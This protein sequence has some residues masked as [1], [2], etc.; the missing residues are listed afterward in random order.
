MINSLFILSTIFFAILL[1]YFIISG[2]PYL[3]F[4]KIFPNYFEKN[5]I[6]TKTIQV[7]DIQR[8]IWYSSQAAMIFAL[9]GFATVKTT[10]KSYTLI[11]DQIYEYPLWWFFLSILIALILH[12]AYFYWTHRIMHHKS[13]YRYFHLV[14]HKSVAPSPWASYSFHFLESFINGLIIPLMVLIL[15]IHPLA[16]MIFTL[17]SFIINVYGHLGYEIMPAHF[18][19]SWM[20][21]VFNSSVHHNLHHSR[22]HGNYGLYL[23]VWDRWMGT[24][25]KDY[26]KEFE[27]IQ[28]Q[29]KNFITNP[30]KENNRE[31]LS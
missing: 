25:I 29:K 14:H 12:D 11:Y 3:L 20:F 31:A 18:S 28:L 21:K 10:F 9:L 17:I 19:K 7:T 24:E 23:R 6:N 13:L 22:F 15:P 2:I 26:E 5:K 1:R 16:L 30:E 8:E 27:R 4:Y